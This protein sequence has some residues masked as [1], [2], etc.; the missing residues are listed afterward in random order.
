MGPLAT[1]N[2]L[3]TALLAFYVARVLGWNPWRTIAYAYVLGEMV[4]LF[5]NL[6]TP[7]AEALGV[8]TGKRTLEP[9]E[10]VKPVPESAH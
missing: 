5:L 9:Q 6:Q 3:G 10:T 8:R 7:V 2:V 1:V 4:H